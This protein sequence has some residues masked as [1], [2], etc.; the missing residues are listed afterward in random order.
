MDSGWE[1]LH[2][3]LVVHW[4][5]RC[6][7]QTLWTSTLRSRSGSGCRAWW[8]QGSVY[9]PS[10]TWSSL[11]PW[12]PPRTPWAAVLRHSVAASNQWWQ[13]SSVYQWL[14]LVQWV[15]MEVLRVKYTNIILIYTQNNLLEIFT[16]MFYMGQSLSLFL[17][18]LPLGFS[19]FVGL[20]VSAFSLSPT[21]FSADTAK[22]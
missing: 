10:S 7:P 16:S 20:V 19:I 4:I 21:S 9:P 6:S 1:Q 17:L 2:P 14:W 13:H 18:N 5:R 22:K 8:C 3:F 12:A 11:L 15:G